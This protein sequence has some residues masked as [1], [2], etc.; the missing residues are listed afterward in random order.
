MVRRLARGQARSCARG[1]LPACSPRPM[2]RWFGSVLAFPPSSSEARLRRRSTANASRPAPS[3]ASISGDR[4][5]VEPTTTGAS[6]ASEPQLSERR[7][8]APLPTDG[9]R[10]SRRATGTR[11]TRSSSSAVAVTSPSSPPS[12][13]S[14]PLA[15]SA[16]PP[17]PLHA[18]A[19]TRRPAGWRSLVRFVRFCRP[20]PDPVDPALRCPSPSRRV[21]PPRRR[22]GPRR[23]LPPDPS[24]RRPHQS[25]SAC[26]PPATVRPSPG[27]RR[28]APPSSPRAT[29]TICAR[30]RLGSR[31]V[32]R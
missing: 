24:R 8:L 4:L 13:P 31:G 16:S 3:P 17:H 11:P 15:S 23:P 21:R 22:I 30:L 20:R 7:P 9:E 29:I 2:R 5:H 25:P 27:A 14:S 26:P 32:G 12:A 10:R 28:S 6:G 18:V 19:I 1:S